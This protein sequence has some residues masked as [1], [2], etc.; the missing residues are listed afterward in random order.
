MQDALHQCTRP[1]DLVP[2]SVLSHIW[3]FLS[4][5]SCAPKASQQPGIF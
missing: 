4:Q 3:A 5:I 2:P 1:G